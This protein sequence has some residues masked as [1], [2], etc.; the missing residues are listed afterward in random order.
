MSRKKLRH[1]MA[2]SICDPYNSVP[3]PGAYDSIRHILQNRRARIA[4][5]AHGRPAPAVPLG[6]PRAGR[7]G[8]SPRARCAKK[9]NRF[10]ILNN[11]S[12]A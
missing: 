1:R 12:D 11:L 4:R 6:R 5:A 3:G 10:A 2:I 7:A 8:A 9:S